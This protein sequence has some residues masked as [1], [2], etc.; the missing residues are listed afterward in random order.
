M[1][2]CAVDAFV[3]E[4]YIAVVDGI[5]IIADF[6]DTAKVERETSILCCETFFTLNKSFD[7]IAEIDV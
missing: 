3:Q 1:F 4:R 5:G 7:E 6:C 2:C